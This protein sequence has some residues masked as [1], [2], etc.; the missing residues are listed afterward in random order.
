MLICNI[1]AVFLPV[2]VFLFF[3]S[4]WNIF[5]VRFLALHNS[6]LRP[7]SLLRAL[8]HIQCT[9]SSAVLGVAQLS[10]YFSFIAFFFRRLSAVR[11]VI[12]S[13]SDPRW[14]APVLSA[15]VLQPEF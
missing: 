7:K 13:R 8:T 14:D 3:F 2:G 4:V 5:P 15:V 9:S 6:Y 11:R 12:A 1:N 10:V